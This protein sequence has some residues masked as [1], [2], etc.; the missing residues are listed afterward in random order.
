[1][2]SDVE[3]SQGMEWKPMTLMRIL[4]HRHHSIRY[5]LLIRIYSYNEWLLQQ[6]FQRSGFISDHH[7]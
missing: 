3:I 5:E 1:M 6:G 7:S 2:V 4:F